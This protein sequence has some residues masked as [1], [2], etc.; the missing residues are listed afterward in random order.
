MNKPVHAFGINKYDLLTTI[1]IIAKVDVIIF[2]G[3]TYATK[4]VHE[5]NTVSYI[6]DLLEQVLADISLVYSGV[7]RINAYKRR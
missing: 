1:P 6:I 7:T 4:E 3:V 5:R 2:D